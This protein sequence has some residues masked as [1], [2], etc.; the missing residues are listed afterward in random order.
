LQARSHPV[1]LRGGKARTWGG[2]RFSFICQRTP[3]PGDNE[4]TVSAFES[5]LSTLRN[6]ALI[7]HVIR[8]MSK[9][10]VR[11]RALGDFYNFCNNT[12]FLGLNSC[13]LL[14]FLGQNDPNKK[15]QGRT[16]KF[17]VKKSPSKNYVRKFLI[18]LT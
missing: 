17:R 18:K 4:G 3:R 1:S 8:K 7:K 9:N 16:Q 14:K 12:T 13:S 2:G 10:R 11:A 15:D 6:K 5:S